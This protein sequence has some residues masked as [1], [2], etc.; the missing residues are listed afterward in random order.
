MNNLRFKPAGLW[1]KPSHLR[2]GGQAAVLDAILL[3]DEVVSSEKAIDL[4]NSAQLRSMKFQLP[5]FDDDSFG[6]FLVEY[7]HPRLV[8]K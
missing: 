5:D 4:W 7:K 8:V 3:K 1:P 6:T 2:V